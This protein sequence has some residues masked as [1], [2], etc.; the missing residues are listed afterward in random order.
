MTEPPYTV[1][2]L[3]R[4]DGYQVPWALE[5]AGQLG[6][7]LTGAYR[8]QVPPIIDTALPPSFR[9]RL[10]TRHCRGIPSNKVEAHW[11]VEALQS[12]SGLL[13]DRSLRSWS[14][15]NKALSRAIRDRARE[16]R[17]SI[18]TYE[19]YGWEAF[20]AEYDHELRKVLFHFHLHPQFEREILARDALSNPPE[21]GSWQKQDARPEWDDRVVDLWRHADRVLCASSFTRSSLVAQGMPVEACHVIPYG[22]DLPETPTARS[23]KHF[24]VLFVGSGIQRK[25]LHHLLAAWNAAELPSDAILTVVCRSLDPVLENCLANSQRVKVLRGVSPSELEHLFRTSSLFAMPSLLEGFGQVFLEALA[26]GCPVLGT[27]NTCLP[28]LGDESSGIH[29]VPAGDR[30]AI[31]RK[32]EILSQTLTAGDNPD[33]RAAARRLAERFTW[34]RFRQR[35]GKT[36][37]DTID[38]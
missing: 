27:P 25:G 21:K 20:T 6:S 31:R 13:H 2:F 37:S 26:H 12:L 8:D 18:L 30:E 14:W 11:R 4:R 35:L 32:L 28:D 22:I 19:P 34:Q 16:R 33:I 1:G 17:E 5:E 10:A 7:F 9:T 15:A 24:S 3:G 38:P 23:T 29:V 36:V